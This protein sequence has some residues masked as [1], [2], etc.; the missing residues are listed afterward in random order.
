MGGTRQLKASNLAP[1]LMPPT[2]EKF[3]F[4]FPIVDVNAIACS[5]LRLIYHGSTHGAFGVSTTKRPPLDLTKID[6]FR[7]SLEHLTTEPLSDEYE[8]SL[9]YLNDTLSEIIWDGKMRD[10]NSRLPEITRRVVLAESA[11]LNAKRY[12][13][14]FWVKFQKPVYLA[15]YNKLLVINNCIPVEYVESFH[16]RYQGFLMRSK[17]GYPLI[18]N[19]LKAS[20]IPLSD[21]S[22][23][24]DSMDSDLRVVSYQSQL[25][26]I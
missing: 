25:V 26:A 22:H 21:R 15:R 20:G 6:A 24:S 11:S 16:K 9:V 12:R 18:R 5:A 19:T 4:D 1:P 23:L 14:P 17:K 13:T 2:S 7:I 8:Y 3:F 10:K